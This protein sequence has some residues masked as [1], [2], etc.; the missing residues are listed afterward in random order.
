MS[1]VRSA[2]RVPKGFVVGLVLGL[3]FASAG[4]VAAAHPPVITTPTKASQVD[5]IDVARLE[6][7]NYYGTPGASTG[8]AATAGWTLEL[9]PDSNY[10]K[11]AMKV[12]TRGRH[13]LD[14][15][16]GKRPNQAIILD[17]DDT[18]LATWNY[19]LYSN[20]DFNP[21]TN[22]Q[23]VGLTDVDPSPAVNNQFTG[24]AFPA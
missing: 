10:A 12:A 22:A 1:R 13:L 23:F 17:V 4:I 9:N 21:I 19:E 2:W 7:K 15:R 6:I 11:E 5:N 20:W 3:I 18:T 14:A 8:A 16:A 24:N